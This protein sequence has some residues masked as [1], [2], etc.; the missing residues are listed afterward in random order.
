M[1]LDLLIRGGTVID[2]SGGKRFVADV[3]ISNGHI[4]RIGRI[5]DTATRTIDADGLIVTPG[6]HRRPHPHGCAD[7]LGSAGHCSC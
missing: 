6:L 2:G 1:A 5:T 7:H 4:A 3:G